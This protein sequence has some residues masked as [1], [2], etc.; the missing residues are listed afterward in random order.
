MEDQT[1]G[2]LC[3]RAGLVGGQ[4]RKLLW[5]KLSQ[6]WRTREQEI[7]PGGDADADDVSAAAAA[8]S[9]S[10]QEAEGSVDEGAEPEREH[11]AGRGLRTLKLFFCFLGYI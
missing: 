3:G 10:E 4:Q 8:E 5:R 2:D 9:S 1:S 11:E 7:P 6:R